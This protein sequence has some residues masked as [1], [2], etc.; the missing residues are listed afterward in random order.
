[1]RNNL[2]LILTTRC[3]FKCKHCIR[4]YYTKQYDLSFSLIKKTL[5]D[6]KE[7][8]IKH[9][10]L[11]GGE[12][13]LYPNFDALIDLISKFGFTWSIVTNGS[14]YKKYDYSIDRHKSNL[15]FIAISLDGGTEETHDFMRQKGS[16]KD[17]IKA[18]NYYLKKKIFVRLA[19]T[20]SAK[21]IKDIPKFIE[22]GV[23]LNVNA[24][25]IGG[26][27]ATGYN[28]D[29][30]L[31]WAQKKSI[32]E[33][34]KKLKK[35]DLKVHID[36]GT[37]LYTFTDENHFCANV[38]DHEPTINASGEYIYCCDTVGQGAVLGN[39]KNEDFS[40]LYIKGIKKAT[41][42]KNERRKLIL[43]KKFFKDFNSCNYCNTM[44]KNELHLQKKIVLK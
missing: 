1:M 9:L 7:L 29:L 14:M 10:G 36:Y 17:V 22:L 12:P 42:L 13:I 43:K 34:I 25:K 8:G 21:N 32:Q 15:K 2:V 16:Y 33:Y 37:S 28:K 6:A 30:Q 11:T 24:L 39:I 31:T 4:E 3:N 5:K 38:D 40:D 35:S 27:I 26:T 20:A 44:L 41:W 19:M 18:V 23:K